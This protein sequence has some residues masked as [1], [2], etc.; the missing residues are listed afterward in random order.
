MSRGHSK[1]PKSSLINRTAD[2]CFFYDHLH[3]RQ[4]LATLRFGIEARKGLILL[5]GESGVG[6]TTLLHMLTSKLETNVTCIWVG[7]LCCDFAEIIRLILHHLGIEAS[8][9]GESA[10]TE[11]CFEILRSRL[12]NNLMVALIFD[13]AHHLD[14]QMLEPVIKNLLKDPARSSEKTLL[15]IV[16]SGRPEL[17]D[18]LRQPEFRSAGFPV[19]IEYELPILT[20]DDIHHYVEQRLRFGGLSTELFSRA[21]VQLIAAYSG[22]RAQL[23]NAICDRALETAIDLSRQPISAEIIAGAIKDLDLRQPGSVRKEEPETDF[24]P[25]RERDVPYYLNSDVDTTAVVGQTFLHYNNSSD[26]TKRFYDRGWFRVLVM[27]LFVL[28]AARSLSQFEP[29]K[30]FASDWSET[31]REIAGLNRPNPVQ[32]NTVAELPLATERA[33]DALAPPRESKN[34]SANSDNSE[35]TEPP[36]PEMKDSVEPTPS[37][38]AKTLRSDSTKPPPQT[39]LKTRP[40]HPDSARVDSEATSRELAI[41]IS[42]AIEN[43][44]IPGIGVAVIDNVAYLDGRVASE[45]Q[46]RVVER[47]AR[48]VGQI[49]AVRNRIVVD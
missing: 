41:K 18:K 19:G 39:P 28:G 45:A 20:E 3:F 22:G 24:A 31:V 12:E 8:A 38:A 27:V 4:A 37:V 15:Q 42:K 43:R 30:R 14:N 40:S 5:T 33:T 47:A 16:L 23:V 11:R 2:P 17:R 21:A 9:D 32:A 29:A 36:M 49:R 10:M 1:S 34:L 6:K 35:A 7:D 44:A 46:R 25:R 48:G 13:N 26:R